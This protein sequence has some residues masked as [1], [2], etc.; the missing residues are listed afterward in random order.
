[1]QITS[2]RIKKLLWNVALN[3]TV[4]NI[5]AVIWAYYVLK[6]RGIETDPS[7]IPS[8]PYFLMEVVVYY[9]CVATVFYYSHR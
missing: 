3:H 2:E 6:W 9:I 7:K 8:L 5:P 4:Y 1:M